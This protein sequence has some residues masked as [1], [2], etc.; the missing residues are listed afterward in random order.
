MVTRI[1]LKWVAPLALAFCLLTSAD[2]AQAQ[3]KNQQFGF[4]GGYSFLGEDSGLKPHSFLLGMR[5]GYKGTDHWWFTSRAAVSFRGEQNPLS[6]RTVVVFNVM[7]V[8]ARYYFL[9]DTFRPFVGAGST[10]NLLF[11]QSIESTVFWGPQATVGAEIKLQRD[12]FL[13]FQADL[14]WAFVFQGADAP[15]ATMTTQLLF[16]L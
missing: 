8:D 7:P 3:Y 13:G 12:I 11:N 16:F 5:G 10:F 2:E 4:E 6:N 15:F 14:G 9:T 1:F